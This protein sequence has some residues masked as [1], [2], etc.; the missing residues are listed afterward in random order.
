MG[1]SASPTGLSSQAAEPQASP[2]SASIP[3]AW[4][5]GPWDY[6]R[7]V[8]PRDA[9]RP[10]VGR[11]NENRFSALACGETADEAWANSRL[12]AAAPELY[13]AL[14]ELLGMLPRFSADLH[15]VFADAVRSARAALAKA[16]GEA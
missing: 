2:P 16:R 14:G 6:E 7:S 8:D 1:A 9:E 15:P 11:L 10:W 4:T 12:I 13:E 5:A 3:C